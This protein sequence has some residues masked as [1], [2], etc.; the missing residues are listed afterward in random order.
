MNFLAHLYLSGESKEIM[1]GNFIADSV[2][3]KMARAYSSEIQKGIKL[4]HLIDEYTDSHPVVSESKDRLRDKY[5]LYSGVIIDIFYDHYLSKNFH[6]YS[7]I[8]INQFANNIYSTL[9]DEFSILPPKVKH[10]LPYMKKHN[11]LVSYGNLEG[12]TS[13]LNGMSRR[14]TFDSKMD[15]SIEELKTHYDAFWNE[16]KRFFPQLEQFVADQR[17]IL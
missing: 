10:L 6:K 11:W 2:T 17:T 16:F 13:V 4:H 12:M 1:I 7:S 14:A 9:D 8:S 3:S 15:E 5:G